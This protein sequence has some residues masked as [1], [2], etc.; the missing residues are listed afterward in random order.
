MIPIIEKQFCPFLKDKCRD[1]CVFRTFI[2]VTDDN[3]LYNCLIAIKL[4]DI[5]G[6]THDVLIK[7]LEYLNKN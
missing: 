1:D 7:V 2:V 6:L 5:S 3:V 4:T